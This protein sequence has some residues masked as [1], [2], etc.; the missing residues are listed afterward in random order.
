MRRCTG[1][2][3][4]DQLPSPGD[5]REVAVVEADGRLHPRVGDRVGDRSRVAGRQAHRLLDPQVLAGLGDRDADLA[6]ERCPRV[7]EPQGGT[8]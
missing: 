5:G 7:F 8:I 2:P 3:V 1:T 4:A 6:V